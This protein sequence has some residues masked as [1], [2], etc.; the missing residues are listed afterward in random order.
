MA[1]RS[2]IV[3]DRRPHGVVARHGQRR[4]ERKR[5]IAAPGTGEQEREAAVREL[6]RQR[7]DASATR[8]RNR[9]AGNVRSRGILPAFGVSRVRLRELARGGCMPGVRRSSW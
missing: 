2:K 4:A 7:R 3:R 1:K 8:L 6:R 9:H 5:F